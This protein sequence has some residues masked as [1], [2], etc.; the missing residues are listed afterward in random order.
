MR[1]VEIYQ[2]GGFPRL[3]IE[4]KKQFAST[5][6]LNAEYWNYFNQAEYPEALGYLKTNLVDLAN[7]YHA[8]Y[9]NAKFRRN[10]PEN[11]AEAT[12]WYRE[13]LKSFPKDEQSPGIN[14]QLADLLLENK[15]Y[16]LAAFEYERSAYDYPVND[17]SSKAAYAAVYAYRE[18]LKNCT[19]LAG[20]ECQS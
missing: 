19:R 17:K 2:K 9:Q 18:Q 16:K 8:M 7:H 4:A 11:F 10:K 15:D 14:Y 3:V 6:G 13:F 20:K 5:Y 12:H 1:V